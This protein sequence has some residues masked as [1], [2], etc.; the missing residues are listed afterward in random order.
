LRNFVAVLIDHHRLAQM[1]EIAEKFRHE[2]NERLGIAEAYVTSARELG[3]EERQLLER[4]IQAVT[5]KVVAEMYSLDP[6]R[7]GCGEGRIGSTIYDGSVRGQLSR[8]KEQII[9][10]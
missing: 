5:G 4:Q 10:N 3:K 6:N 8:I 9:T 7:L 1:G 2:L